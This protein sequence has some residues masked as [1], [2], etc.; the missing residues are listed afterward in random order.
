MREVYVVGI[1]I[2]LP[3]EA[4]VLLL[5][6]AASPR[7]LPVWISATEAA[8][9][10]DALEEGTDM[11]PTTHDLLVEVL[12]TLGVKIKQVRIMDVHEG[13]FCAELD[14]GDRGV[15]SA[16]VSDSIVL[17]LRLHIPVLCATK[18]LTEVGIELA[19]GEDAEIEAFREFLSD[20]EADDFRS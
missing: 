18:V 14:L 15:V 9:I 7:L 12:D 11:R 20:V 1:R 13:I 4:P 17:A 5:K 3:S 19:G 16:R 6:D 2:D 10:V 8:A